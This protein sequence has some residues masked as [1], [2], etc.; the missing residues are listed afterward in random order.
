MKK[1][2][3][4]TKKLFEPVAPLKKP[5]KLKPNGVG[6]ET[7]INRLSNMASAEL[8]RNIVMNAQSYTI[9]QVLE[10]V[11]EDK[12]PALAKLNKLCPLSR[13]VNVGGMPILIVKE[14]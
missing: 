14:N 12:M 3:I 9:F 6:L 10:V 7:R 13:V 8:F 4:K 5:R 2:G 1:P 11:G